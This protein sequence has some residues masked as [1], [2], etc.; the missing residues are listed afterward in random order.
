MEYII[1]C[2]IGSI[3]GF[4][5]GVIP[6]AGATTGLLTVFSLAHFF[7]ADPYLGLAFLISLVAAS[8]TGD[9]YTSI[10]TGIPGGGQ[11]AASIIDGHPMAKR[12]EG[13][14]AI[15]IALI[16]S[17]INGL[18]WGT[19]AFAFMPYY[20]KIVLYFGIPEFAAFIFLSLAC[21]G[22]IT[23]KSYIR[24][25]VAISLGMFLG[26]IG[27]DPSTAAPRFTFGWEY[28]E[29]GIQFIPMI[30][31]LFAVPELIEG[32]H[33]RHMR[34][35]S[36]DKK[37]YW[38]QMRQAWRDCREN[39]RDV[40]R[41]GVIG[42]ITGMLPGA[43]GTI[44]DIV[45]YGST[46]AKHSNEKFGN[47]NPKGLLGC[48]GANNAQKASSMIP[49]LLFGIPAA[50]FA[51]VVMAVCMY[52]GLELGT[53]SLLEDDR[54]I[55]AVGGSFVAATIISCVIGLFATRLIVKILEIPYWI[56][57]SLIIAVIT[58]AC[59]QYTQT[60]NDFY[61]LFICSA[62]GIACKYFQISRPAVLLTFI[63][64]E[65]LENYTQ[66]AFTLYDWTVFFTRPITLTLIILGVV[67][68]I[69]SFTR[70]GRGIDYN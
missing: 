13:A 59:F 42:F 47:G 39:W 6:V 67:L 69:W 66:Q 15:G 43:G 2:L 56:Y 28:L 9:S 25:A 37:T 33:Q 22:L 46:V 32:W 63:V 18:I 36:I 41:G 65:K 44:G 70:R 55:W 38:S 4:V 50:P 51:A 10:L 21:V 7:Q 11:T 57:S 17:T 58:W 31:G 62:I 52:F 3:Y 34:I 16:D 23:S 26:L 8:S 49:T 54:M 19:L 14:R 27:L 64:S 35:E 5:I 68:L 40:G 60:V 1:W 12:G 30:A 24:A 20:S 53:P 29:A 48:E 45:A 61:I